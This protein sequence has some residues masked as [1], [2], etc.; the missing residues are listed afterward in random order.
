M[1]LSG[2]DTTFQGL[3]DLIVKEQFINSC[4]RDLAVYLRERTLEDLN[5]LGKVAESY[6]TAPGKQMYRPT[7]TKNGVSSNLLKQS[8]D[9]RKIVLYLSRVR[10]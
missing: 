3:S 10:T 8:S 6:L 7:Q 4:F 5:E 2:T 9:P 1:D